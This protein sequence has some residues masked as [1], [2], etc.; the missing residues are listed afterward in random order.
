MRRTVFSLLLIFSFVLPLSAQG[1][2]KHPGMKAPGQIT[3]DG[4]GVPYIR[5][6]TD[7]DVAFLNGWVHAEDRLFQMDYNRRQASGTLAELFGASALATDVQLRTF[8]IR[9]GAQLSEIEASPRLKMLMGAYA[10]G[11]NAYVSSHSLP[12]E[13]AA[14]EIT[15]FQPWTAT[16][17][18]AVGKLIAFGLSFGTEDIDNT[19]ALLTY[20]GVGAVAGFDG[21][22][23][24]S[25]DLFRSQPFDPA[26]TVPDAL[27][28][29]G[30]ML[31]KRPITGPGWQ[32][33]AARAVSG[34][35]PTTIE[36]AKGWLDQLR[37][38]PVFDKFTNEEARG[39]SN[40]WAIAGELT[41]TGNPLMA[42]DPHLALDMPSTFYPLSI[43]GP[44]LNAAGIGFPGAPLV[45]QGHT[46]R[47]A[48]GSTVNPLDVTDFFEEQIVP[49][50]A[51]PVGLSVL[52]NGKK[53]APFPVLQT[54]RANTV[55]NGVTDDLVTIPGEGLAG[56]PPAVTL[57]LPHRNNG[58]IVDADLET[59]VAISVQYVGHGPTQEF[60]CF[61]RWNSAKNLAD[62]KAGLQYFDVGSQNFIYTDADGNIAYFTSGEMPLREDLQAGTVTGV[63]PWFIRNGQG[64]NDWIPRKSRPAG[65]SSYFEVLPYSEMPQIEN[66]EG[67]W[68]VNANNDPAGTTLDNNPLNQVRP[69]GGLYYLNPDY[70]GFRAGRITQMV[71][72]KVESG[73]K[74]SPDDMKS[75]QADVT[76]L[77]AQFFVPHILQAL[78]NAQTSSNLAL[79]A[80]A[81]EPAINLAIGQLATWDFTAPTGIPEGY[82]ASD[83]NGQLGS[84]TL[85]EITASVSTTI[86]SVWRGQFIKNSIDALLGGIQAQA[87]IPIPRPGSQQVVTA[88][89]NILENHDTNFGYGASGLPFFNVPGIPPTPQT[90]ADRRD[91]IILVS[92][93]DALGV[94]T[95][96]EFAPAF[97]Q[98]T[99]PV[100]WRW[101]KLHRIVF[102][103]PLGGPF[104][105]PS[106]GGAFP[107]PL[108]G[109]SGIP[110]DGGFEVVDASS[111]NP[112][113]AGLNSFMFGS[114]PNRRTVA[115]GKSSGI[116]SVFSLPG[117]ISGVL[118]SPLYVNL[119][120]SYLTNDTFTIDVQPAGPALPW[121]AK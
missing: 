106:A 79:K 57:V 66:P 107:A 52:S 104:S 109:L 45:V 83:A 76:L 11:V 87:G 55:G 110:V 31:R 111:H 90:A 102:D 99:D 30:K 10:A 9:R 18:F 4:N 37:Q 61:M 32:E 70:S 63:P 92:I 54:W 21:A 17:C 101:G 89:R 22:K 117:G 112:R 118:G 114:G 74:I 38:M 115:E 33:S 40:E 6:M 93:A 97:G 71:R 94:I 73:S 120:K 108:E 119:L 53:V 116:E 47:I 8:G 41:T 82:D 43:R 103:H 46:D 27:A 58:P 69:G 105:T 36:L 78:Q 29:S 68:I 3:R 50:A 95:S 20:A 60:E 16:D 77:D 80:L 25:E 98:S 62:F 39:A 13:Y 35:N 86:Y 14:L 96:E 44:G 42:N 48:W 85:Q 15:K 121:G 28:A 23:L 84:P 81:A 12:P 65:Q 51:S 91:I 26:S 7:Y 34:L 56:L 100:T 72:A 5:A 88:L 1:W 75:M 59:G 24:F 19:V 64:G 113:A 2:V 49:D 67:G